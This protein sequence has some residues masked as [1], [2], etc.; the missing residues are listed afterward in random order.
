VI[1]PGRLAVAT[2]AAVA[3]AAGYVAPSRFEAHRLPL[4]FGCPPAGGAA[5]TGDVAE[6]AARAR[7][8]EAAA[9]RQS[10]GTADARTVPQVI[11]VV[12][13]G[14]PGLD[15]DS[16]GTLLTDAKRRCTQVTSAWAIVA[17]RRSGSADACCLDTIFV[18][19]DA[20]RWFVF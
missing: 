20:R 13:L 5:A 18:A 11:A 3:F 8:V 4:V 6:I 17:F 2:A 19:C 10:G 15:P 9:L 1:F 7:S 12:A 14:L 16:T